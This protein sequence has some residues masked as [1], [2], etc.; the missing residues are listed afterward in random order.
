[1]GAR[2]EFRGL[3]SYLTDLAKKCAD[4]KAI[5]GIE[6]QVLYE[7]AK[8]YADALRAASQPYGNLSDGITLSKMEESDGWYT[9]LGFL[10]YDTDGKAFALKAAII[11]SGT[12]DN[13]VTGNNF[14]RKAFKAADPKAQS[15][16]DAKFNELMEK[17][18]E[19]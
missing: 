7:G 18:M 14:I 16:M 8:V 9:K 3:S 11:N 17:F 4:A 2:F 1:M 10:G 6:K 5:N 13:R 15:A 19:G 12:S